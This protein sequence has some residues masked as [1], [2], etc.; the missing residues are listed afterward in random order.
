MVILNSPGTNRARKG[1]HVVGV[2]FAEEAVTAARLLAEEVGLKE[3]TK[4]L[5]SN[6]YDTKKTLGDDQ[7]EF[8]IVFTSYGVLCWLP[9]LKNWAK[10]AASCLKPGGIFYIAESHPFCHTWEQENRDKEKLII[11]G[12]YFF[13]KDPKIDD[14]DWSY[15]GL[16]LSKNCKMSMWQHSLSDIINAVLESG[17]SLTFVHEFP[18]EGFQRYPCMKQKEKK[19]VWFLPDSVP[20]MPMTFSLMAKKPLK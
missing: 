2:D 13:D 17:L 20:K 11:K 18:W 5:Q 16:Q 14:D 8:D 10:A 1:A 9:D 19:G 4:F 15:T 7:S 12:N 3:C 6:V